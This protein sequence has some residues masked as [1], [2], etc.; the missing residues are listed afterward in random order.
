[1]LKAKGGTCDQDSEVSFETV[2]MSSAIWSNSWIGN[3]ISSHTR[4]VKNVEMMT[5]RRSGMKQMKLSIEERNL[6]GML[7]SLEYL[8]EGFKAVKKNRGS[9]GIDG[10]TIGEFASRLDEELVQ[11]KKELESWMYKPKPV[12]RVEI[13][14]PGKGAGVRL[15]GVPCIRDR[16][17]QATLKLILEPIL[18]PLF[19]DNSYGFRPGC[20]QRQAVESAQRIVR[21]GKEYV[22]DIDLSKFFDRVHHDHLISRLSKSISDKRIL[23]IIGMTLRSGVMKEGLV[24][25]TTEGTVQGSPLSP[26]LSNVVLDELDKEL[27]CRELEFCRFADDCNIFVKSSKAAERVMQNVSEFIENKLKLV[28]NQKKSK[29]ALSKDVKFLGMT[30]IAGTVAISVQSMNRAMQ[31]V[32]ELTPRG[33]HLALEETIERINS[34]YI[35]W[36]SYYSMTQYPSQLGNIEAHIRRRL[37]SRLVDQQK[38]RRYLFKKLVKRNV[39][40]CIAAKTVFSNRRRWALSHTRAVERAYPNRWFIKE[41]GLRIRSVE[42]HPHW[43]DIHQWV[44]VA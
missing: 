24:T 41:M 36:S 23:R 34:W 18:D 9:P 14:K 21:S 3:V 35:G 22:V 29:F 42:R 13:P 44:K 26:L 7:C 15:L 8:K 11:L 32:K 30:I 10:V 1:M 16:V 19:S 39:P 20:N 37:R 38:R 40:R 2:I 31:K 25:S 27:E 43:F 28:V 33:T 4:I 12:R 5:Q 17:V 6:F